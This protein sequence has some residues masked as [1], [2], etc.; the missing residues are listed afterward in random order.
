MKK[1]INRIP[2]FKNEDEERE[3]WATHSPLDYFD[4]KKLKRAS[5]PKLKPSLKSISIR[6]PE[7]MLA[8]LK[9]LAN[10]KDV[11]YQSLAKMYLARQIALERGFINSSQ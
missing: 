2:K 6:L 10:K 9:I 1:A 11:P 7:D 3:F 8:E 5:F 4:A